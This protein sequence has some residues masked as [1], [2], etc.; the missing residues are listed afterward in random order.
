MAN[1]RSHPE[2]S[3]A[4]KDVPSALMRQTLLDREL[5]RPLDRPVIRLLP[6]LNVVV[7]GGRS[8]MDK[9]R[10]AVLPVVEELRAA[11]LEHRLLILTGPGIRGRHV[12]GVGLD[13]GLPTGVLA[14]LASADAEQNGHLIA[15][16]LAEQGVS[17]LPHAAIAHQL[18]VHLSASRA[19]VSN[20]YPPYELYEFPPEV[21]KIPPHRTDTGAFLLADAYGAARIIYVKDVDGVF[22][23]DPTI[24]D[25]SRP[26]FI[27]R[28]G[29]AQL[30]AMNLDTLPVDTL[31]VE[32]MAHA[33]HL[34][35]IHIVN[36]LTPGNITKA[37]Q[38]EHV[39]TLIHAD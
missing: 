3:F 28:V 32:L 7:I 31:A 39:G 26:E 15:A 17:Y 23:T 6:W 30:L 11:L 10:D 14:A 9:G 20:G 25:G 18:A 35:E 19:V 22:T 36:G 16:L 8:I 1:T 24:T 4:A 27:P 2:P 5:V 29:A 34:T 21:G 12:L 13:L 33:K 38:G 37:L